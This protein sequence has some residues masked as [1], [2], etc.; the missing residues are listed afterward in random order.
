MILKCRLNL[1]DYKVA[2]K[3]KPLSGIIIKSY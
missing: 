1:T 3:N 2:Q